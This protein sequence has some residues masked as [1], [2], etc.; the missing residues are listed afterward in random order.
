MAKKRRKVEED[1]E[2]DDTPTPATGCTTLDHI[3]PDTKPDTKCYCGK[4]VWKPFIKL[5]DFL[6]EGMVIR[7]IAGGALYRIE[8]VNQ[9]RARC[10]VT[11]A[12]AEVEREVEVLH[13][14]NV[15][16]DEETTGRVI[17][18]S[19][20]SAVLRVST[21]ELE[22][23]ALLTRTDM[24]KNKVATIPVAGRSSRNI[25][26]AKGKSNGNGA[27]RTRSKAERVT[28]PCACGCGDE[29]TA[30]FVPGHDARF[31][32]WLRKIEKGEAAPADLLPK[33]IRSKY[34]FV[35]RG[36]GMVPK[37]DYKGEKYVPQLG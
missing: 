29:T 26:A 10:R 17:N 22:Q 11:T 4:R 30:Y 32:G 27:V 34:E 35:K 28:K 21:A 16:E 6:K 9:S 18:I 33:S 5:D 20:R 13:L 23:E 31:K 2:L 3:Y 7:T 1:D 37:L 24:A 15:V 36:K 14:G 12:K 19:P 25:A 8:M